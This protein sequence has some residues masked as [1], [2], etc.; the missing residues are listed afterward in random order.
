MHAVDM[1][2]SFKTLVVSALVK[3]VFDHVKIFKSKSRQELKRETVFNYQAEVKWA[4]AEDLLV[5]STL[6]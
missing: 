2:V 1:E 3:V 4:M 6:K 5:I